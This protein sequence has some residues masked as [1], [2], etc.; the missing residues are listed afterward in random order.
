MLCSSTSSPLL[1]LLL[2]FL[3]FFFFFL[4]FIFISASVWIKRIYW[5][6][7]TRALP[8][9]R[10][11]NV[12]LMWWKTHRSMVS[13]T[14]WM[15]SST[16]VIFIFPLSLSASIRRLQ[17]VST[18]SPRTLDSFRYFKLLPKDLFDDY[19]I[20][21][22]LIRPGMIELVRS[23]AQSN[24]FVVQLNQLFVVIVL[25]FWFFGLK[26]VKYADV[27]SNL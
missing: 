14:Q 7:N 16:D 18:V 10:H 3:I 23:F 11:R 20:C 21:R 9:W 2:F 27:S 19:C 5:I 25:F 13:S 24:S 1:S 8:K 26:A 15:C 12:I 4:G 17:M 6:F 22:S